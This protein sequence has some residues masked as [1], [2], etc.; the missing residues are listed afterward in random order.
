[1]G[2]PYSDVIS[3][4]KHHPELRGWGFGLM[5][6]LLL[7]SELLYYLELRLFP[8][9]FRLHCRISSSG[10]S[11]V[12]RAEFRVRTK[13]RLQGGRISSSRLNY[14]FKSEFRQQG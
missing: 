14:V 9:K 12:F 11:A 2:H 4:F 7:R 8:A 3:E 6:C 1:M 5:G 10:S 13:F